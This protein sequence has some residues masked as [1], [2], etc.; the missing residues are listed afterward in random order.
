MFAADLFI[1]LELARA[2]TGDVTGLC[3]NNEVVDDAAGI[4]MRLD[5]EGNS[6][7]A[8]L[9]LIDELYVSIIAV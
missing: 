1:R 5:R 2:M 9:L 8:D 7:E 3:R 4:F 6:T